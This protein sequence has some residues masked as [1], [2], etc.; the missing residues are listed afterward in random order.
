[1][2]ERISE[3]RGGCVRWI[4][5]TNPAFLP[6]KLFVSG[7]KPKATYRTDIIYIMMCDVTFTLP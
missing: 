7:L 5:Q 3:D 1:M 4:C 2:R 6:G